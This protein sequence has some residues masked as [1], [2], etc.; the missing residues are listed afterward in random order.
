MRSFAAAVLTV[1]ASWWT[2]SGDEPREWYQGDISRVPDY[3][4]FP[5]QPLN[6]AGKTLLFAC[7]A[8]TRDAVRFRWRVEHPASVNVSL[9]SRSRS[10]YLER[11]RGFY[12]RDS[13]LRLAS[14][15]PHDGVV[16]CKI[17]DPET[18]AEQTQM[19]ANYSVLASVGVESCARHTFCH[20]DRSSCALDEAQGLVCRCLEAFPRRDPFHGVCYAGSRL[21]DACVFDHECAANDSWC[22]DEVCAC[23]PSFMRVSWHCLP[24]ARLGEPCA[25]ARC[26]GR[27]AHCQHGLCACD[28]EYH[29]VDGVCVPDATP[30]DLRVRVDARSPGALRALRVDSAAWLT[31]GGFCALLALV[32]LYHG[33]TDRRRRRKLGASAAV[34]ATESRE[35]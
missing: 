30:D 27:H 9:S 5:R 6:A 13:V 14:G 17:L 21:G 10:I 15:S 2:A 25:Q 32:A 7:S 18:G 29:D 1:A 12:V 20:R 34:H 26:P 11:G 23:R 31:L 33:V 22:Q 19:R 4:L 8:A 16:H 28:A 24:T 3:H 35:S